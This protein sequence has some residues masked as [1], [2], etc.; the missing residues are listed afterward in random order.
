MFVYTQGLLVLICYSNRT[1]LRYV[2]DRRISA[3]R[4]C[5]TMPDFIKMERLLERS[6]SEDRKQSKRGSARLQILLDVGLLIRQTPNLKLSTSIVFIVLSK[7]GC[8]GRIGG[9]NKSRCCEQTVWKRCRGAEQFMVRT[10]QTQLMI[11]KLWRKQ[12]R[13]SG[14]KRICDETEIVSKRRREARV[15][16]KES[17]ERDTETDSIEEPSS[18]L[19]WAR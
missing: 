3:K 11:Q 2:Q 4:G 19:A 17:K 10:R 13:K 5:T 6:T 1:M 8:D 9:L 18:P 16:S 14:V 12:N 15:S 7:K